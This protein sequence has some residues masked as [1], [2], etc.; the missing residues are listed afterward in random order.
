MGV[1]PARRRRVVRRLGI[2]FFV[3]EKEMASHAEHYAG[4]VKAL[5]VVTSTSTGFLEFSPRDPVSQASY[6]ASK[7][8]WLGVEA[9]EDAVDRGVFA[10]DTVPTTAYTSITPAPKSKPTKEDWCSIQ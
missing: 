9:S 6:D 3:R 1:A 2:L 10:E 4:Y 8:S 7:P 5:D